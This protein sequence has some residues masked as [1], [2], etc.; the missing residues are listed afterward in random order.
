MRTSRRLDQVKPSLTL[1]FDAR[2][3]ALK[4]AGRDV[5]GLAAGEP[6]FEPSETVLQAAEEAM[7]HGGGRYTA[8]AGTPALRQAAARA[9]EELTGIRYSSDRIAVSSGAK[10]SIFNALYA[11]ADPGDE[12]IVPAPYWT[13]YPEMCLALGIKPVIVPGRADLLPDLDGIRAAINDRTRAIIVNSP[14]NPTGRVIDR[15]TLEGLAVLMRAWPDLVLISDDIYARLVF[16]GHR[17][18]NLPMVAPDLVERTILVYGMSKTYCMT[19]WR[20]GFAAGPLEIIKQI[21][22]V[23]GH[24]T[25]CANS[26]A[27]AAACRALDET[28][29]NHIARMVTAYRERAGLFLDSFRSIG[30]LP[31]PEPQGAFYLFPRVDAWFGA[32]LGDRRIGSALDLAQLLL[33]EALLG[34]VPGEA[35]GAPESIRIS[36]ATATDKVREACFRLERFFAALQR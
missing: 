29:E 32:R 35:F 11:L 9:I 14:G 33:D 19:G 1:E 22:T 3:K 21:A 12:V 26:I 6:D 15:A 20:I 17:F 7:R 5:I 30:D 8:V 34:V 25:S 23:Q 10:H 13:S 36:Y 27:Q 2:A 28:D 18:L 31:C 16:P 4:A 24:S